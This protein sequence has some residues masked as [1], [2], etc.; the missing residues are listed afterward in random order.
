MA[1]KWHI[2]IVVHFIYNLH[3]LLLKKTFAIKVIN[4][5]VVRI[6]ITIT[7]F[8][9]EITLICLQGY[10]AL[11]IVFRIHVNVLS[12][13][14]PFHS[15]FQLVS[16]CVRNNWRTVLFSNIVPHLPRGV[17]NNIWT[18]KCWNK[19]NKTMMKN[20]SF[21]FWLLLFDFQSGSNFYSNF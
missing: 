16:P 8:M 18:V 20:T 6:W 7:S 14:S 5:I 15:T 17:Q 11:W 3:L 9:Y 12:L 13:F 19:C 2:L 1:R 21:S 4:Y 10:F